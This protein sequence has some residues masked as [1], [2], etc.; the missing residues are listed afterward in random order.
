MSDYKDV[1]SCCPHG[2]LARSCEICEL[3]TQK[4]LVEKCEKVLT[5]LLAWNIELPESR[6]VTNSYIKEALAA[7]GP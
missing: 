6:P 7:S 3:A 4:S 1:C 2:Q 5:N